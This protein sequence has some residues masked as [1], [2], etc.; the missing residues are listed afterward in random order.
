MD[1]KRTL[2]FISSNCQAP[3]WALAN[4]FSHLEEARERQE[5]VLPSRANHNRNDREGSFPFLMHAFPFK[6]P[7]PM[8]DAD[9]GPQGLLLR[10]QHSDTHTHGLQKSCEGKGTV[11]PLSQEESASHHLG[12]SLKGGAPKTL[13]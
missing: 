2:I 5:R 11:R 6:G 13:P 10:F 7:F 1:K 12:H 8:C 3:D 9:L 4:W